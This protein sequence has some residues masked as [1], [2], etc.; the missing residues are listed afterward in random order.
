MGPT[1]W[2]TGQEEIDF[3]SKLFELESEQESVVPVVARTNEDE[4]GGWLR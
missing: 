1:G 3:P 2:I 4:G